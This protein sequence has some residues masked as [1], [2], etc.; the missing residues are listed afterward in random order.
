MRP[1]VPMAKEAFTVQYAT[2]S[3]DVPMISC[4]ID[5]CKDM[6]PTFS[7]ASLGQLEQSSLLAYLS[8]PVITLKTNAVDKALQCK[9]HTP[10]YY[11]K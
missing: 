8:N 11:L 4:A 1:L 5:Q 7:I 9:V 2:I 6:K 10:T 3:K